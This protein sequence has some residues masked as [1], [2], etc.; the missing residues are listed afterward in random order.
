MLLGDKKCSDYYI[1][2]NEEL[3][4]HKTRCALCP[5]RNMHLYGCFDSKKFF[6]T[7]EAQKDKYSPSY[8]E[9]LNNKLNCEVK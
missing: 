8:R 3:K 4:N 1:K 2:D 5:L 7:L 9:T 6:D